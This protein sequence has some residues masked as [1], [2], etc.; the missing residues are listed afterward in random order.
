MLQIN[1]ENMMHA[2]CKI[3]GMNFFLNLKLIHDS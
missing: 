3:A 1:L 2:L